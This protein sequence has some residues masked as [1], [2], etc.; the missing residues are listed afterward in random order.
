MDRAGQQE[1]SG[2]ELYEVEAAPLVT[3]CPRHRQMATPI[4]GAELGGRK[5]YPQ[6]AARALRDWRGVL[7][8]HQAHPNC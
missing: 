6:H 2:G 3:H 4:A 1:A 7:I 8:C 5:R